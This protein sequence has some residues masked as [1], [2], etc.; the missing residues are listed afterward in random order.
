MI[1]PIYL[2]NCWPSGGR[3]HAPRSA[4]V[5]RSRRLG[6]SGEE[7]LEDP[8]DPPEAAGFALD[9]GGIAEELAKGVRLRGVSQLLGE[10]RRRWLPANDDLVVGRTQR[11]HDDFEDPLA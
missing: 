1:H 5:A 7:P 9:D 4:C 8:P 3:I 11:G 6:W 2:K 10:L